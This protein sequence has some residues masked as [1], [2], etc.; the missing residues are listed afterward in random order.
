MGDPCLKREQD[1]RRKL[2][3]ATDIR[4]RFRRPKESSSELVWEDPESSVSCSSSQ[5]RNH[6]A[7]KERRGESP[8]RRGYVPLSA[9]TPRPARLS[10]ARPS[11]SVDPA[12][13]C[14]SQS[15]MSTRFPTARRQCGCYP[16]PGCLRAA[17][18]R[19]RR[20]TGI[21]SVH[22]GSKE[23]RSMSTDRRGCRFGGSARSRRRPSKPRQGAR[24]TSAATHIF[25]VW[26]RSAKDPPDNR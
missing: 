16:S 8:M 18:H 6:D 19:H 13:V 22:A 20:S 24:P 4:R 1:R 5:L 14:V 7:Q 11:I 26:G 12:V 3:M 10:A 15:P 2:G 23:L 25:V 17:A 9:R 21:D